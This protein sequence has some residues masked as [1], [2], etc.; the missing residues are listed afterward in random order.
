MKPT[1][2]CLLLLI[3]LLSCNDDDDV[4]FCGYPNGM[5]IVDMDTEN[6]CSLEMCSEDRVVRLDATNVIGT[7]QFDSTQNEYF[8]IYSFTF[9]SKIEILL[10]NLPLELQE[11]DKKVRFSGDVVD[12]CGYFEPNW[13]IEES[14]IVRISNA[15]ELP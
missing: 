4:V 5:T 7:I 3:S 10:C 15:H 12:A 11:V 2:F 13:P 6:D 8:I 1:M 14:Y 9:D